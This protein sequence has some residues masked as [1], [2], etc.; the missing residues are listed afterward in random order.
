MAAPVLP[1]PAQIQQDYL[2]YLSGLQPTLNTAQQ[3]SDWWIRG[4]VV[5]GVVAG[6]YADNLAISNDA[7][8]QSARQA[9]LANWLQT[10]FGPDP[11]QGNFLPATASEG[12]AS[13][14][15]SPGQ[16]VA[17]DLQAVYLPNSNAY[18]VTAF[19][20]LDPVAGTGLVPFQSVS[21]GQS[22]NLQPGAVITFPSPPAGLQAT[23]IVA[24][25]GFTDATDPES[26][27]AAAARILTRLR[28][29]ITV[30]RPI[31]YEQYAKAASPSVV[32]AN[33]V[34]MIY[35]PGTVGIYI[36]AGTTNIDEALDNG[37]VISLLPSAQLIETVQI[38][39]EANAV[40][41]DAVYVLAPVEVPIN[42]SCFVSYLS[43]NGSTIPS[44]QTLTQQQLV[45]REIQRAIYKTPVGG[46]QIPGSGGF[47]FASDIEQTIDIALSDEPFETGTSQI[48]IDRYVEPLSATG[49]NISLAPEQ[50]PVPGTITITQ[51]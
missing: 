23:A 49:N 22:Q 37:Q 20:A 11:V 42:V 39:V 3:D 28:N 4:A 12:L 43:G 1:T 17:L 26:V 13:V 40:L 45:I 50:I 7:F 14:T 27:S 6:V 33:P 8:P 5:G 47:V 19:T 30:G 9:A 18:F 10:M 38:Y 46:R 51:V 31:D 32:T 29:G 16:I 2:N 24:S 15:G 36:T 21:I 35:G 25:G 48:L 41:T 34:K 44:N